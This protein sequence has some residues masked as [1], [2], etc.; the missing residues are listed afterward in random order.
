MALGSVAQFVDHFQRS[1]HRGIV[2]DGVLGTGD[3]VINGAGQADHGNTAVC[4]CAGTTVGTVTANDDQCINAQLTAL[5]SALI[6]TFLG[7]ELQAACR[8]QNGA[9]SRDDVRNAAQVHF[10]ALAVQQ[11]IV[12]A[13]NA[14]HTEA[15][16]QAC[17][18]NGANC[19]IHTRSVAA[20]GQHTNR[21]D[22]LFH[23]KIPSNCFVIYL[24]ST[25]PLSLGTSSIALLRS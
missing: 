8:I 10:K 9:A 3:I 20:A 19:S 18:D 1:V 12:A 11:A 16:V 5:L 4:Q 17:T 24:W 23:G 22:L 25:Y 6:L 7:L 13:L 2:A 15:L 21:F 14:D